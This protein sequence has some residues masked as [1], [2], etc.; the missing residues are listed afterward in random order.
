MILSQCLGT[1]DE[2]LNEEIEA[3]S[4]EHE[5]NNDSSLTFSPTK[6]EDNLENVLVN[7]F[8]LPKPALL[9]G[10]EDLQHNPD[11]VL[12][13]I[14]PKQLHLKN[15]P[16]VSELS[17]LSCAHPAPAAKTARLAGKKRGV[18][19]TDLKEYLVEQEK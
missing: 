11:N 2:T 6:I 17:D 16:S 12:A 1:S 7:S 9:E 14:V 13:N 18:K 5:E 19:K 15:E 8:P 4:S 10:Q 3:D